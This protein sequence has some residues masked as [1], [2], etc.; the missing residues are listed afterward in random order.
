MQRVWS[1]FSFRGLSG[2]I[3]LFEVGFEGLRV[4]RVRVSGSGF[5]GL[6]LG[7]STICTAISES[8]PPKIKLVA[9]IWAEFHSQ[10]ALTPGRVFRV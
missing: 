9:G 7:K 6:G 8:G 10:T 5:S 4:Y 1:L 2:C 3:G